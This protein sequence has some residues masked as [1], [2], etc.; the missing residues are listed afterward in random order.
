VY[1]LEFYSYEINESVLISTLKDWLARDTKVQKDD[2]ILLS[3][4]EIL[5]VRDDKYVVDLLPEV[6]CCSVGWD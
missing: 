1:T 3:N 2:Q 4:L 6:S 5:D